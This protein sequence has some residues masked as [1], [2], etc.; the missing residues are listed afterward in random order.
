MTDFFNFPNE[1]RAQLRNSPVRCAQAFFGSIDNLAL[2]YNCNV[3]LRAGQFDERVGRVLA[4][5]ELIMMIRG[6]IKSTAGEVGGNTR[7]PF[8]DS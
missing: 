7:C 5:E 8:L 6:V 4:A 1:D 3:I 2:S